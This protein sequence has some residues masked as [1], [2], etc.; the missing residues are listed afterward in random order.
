MSLRTLSL[1]AATIGYFAAAAAAG[2][3][4]YV[5]PDGI[6]HGIGQAGGTLIVPALVAFWWAR[7]RNTPVRMD[8]ALGV[9]AIVYAVNMGGPVSS[10]FDAR[11]F[12]ASVSAVK[13][14]NVPISR[15]LWARLEYSNLQAWRG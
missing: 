3:Y 2:A 15:G 10:A 13:T 1:W 8:V 5:W 11:S 12:R 9:S 6:A 4:V 7:K 14:P